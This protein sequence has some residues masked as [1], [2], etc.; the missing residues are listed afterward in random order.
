VRNK[1][2]LVILFS[3]LILSLISITIFFA[4]NYPRAEIF[5][6]GLLNG[7]AGVSIDVSKDWFDIYSTVFLGSIRF[8]LAYILM[9]IASV[10]LFW[11]C[12]ALIARRAYFKLKKRR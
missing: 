2:T 4:F 5:I 10:V 6:R 11:V 9:L 3:L 8:S 1:Y 7:H 12:L